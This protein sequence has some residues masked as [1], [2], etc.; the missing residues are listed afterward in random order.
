VIGTG[1]AGEAAGRALLAAGA[2]VTWIDEQPRS[3][4]NI[5]RIA[6][7]AA[8][9][10]LEA[11]AASAGTA[12]LLSDTAVLAVAPDRRVT[13]EAGSGPYTRAFD[14][15]ILACGA[16]DLHH[17]LPGCPAARVTSA[18]SLQALLK[19]QHLRPAGRVIVAGSGPFIHVAA[20]GLVAA[21]AR[22]THVIDRLTRADERRLAPWGVTMPANALELVATR[23]RLR[24]RGTRILTGRSVATVNADGLELDDGTALPCDHLGLTELFAPQTQLARTAGCHQRYSHAG[25]YWVT[26][27]DLDGRSSVA[28]IH[29]CGEGQGIRGW[30]HAAV[31]GRLAAA[32]AARDLGLRPAPVRRG[33]R[34]RQCAYA[35]FGEA[36]ERAQRRR[37][38]ASLPA[39][40]IVCPCEG[41]TVGQVNAAI[42]LGLDDLSSIKVTTRCGMG[43]CQGRY[44]E[45]LV[46]RLIERTGR[47]PRAP[48]R[49]RAFTRPA[50]AGALAAEG[51]DDA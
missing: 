51:T 49:Q 7:T 31:S 28:G 23:R 21:G 41:A 48:L 19:G 47:T 12:E 33:D 5:G 26:E 1:P 17:P 46:C 24:A 50:T 34:L 29:V 14:A 3:G 20:A 6:P 42:D 36:L 37:E 45:P 22:V 11:D 10:A 40:A 43:P 18:G 16:Y 27:T 13:L 8:T 32:A 25:G 9:T 15:V 35:R 39:D 2:G 44:C 30:R 4:G 38:P